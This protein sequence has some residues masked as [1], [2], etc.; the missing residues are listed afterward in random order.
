MINRIFYTLALF[1]SLLGLTQCSLLGLDDDVEEV[2]ITEAFLTDFP[3]VDIDYVSIEITDPEIVDGVEVQ[4]GVINLVVPYMTSYISSNEESSYRKVELALA[5][6]D[7]DLTKYSIA[8]EV[9]GKRVFSLI[10][11]KIYTITSR[12]DSTKLIHYEIHI[13]Q[14]EVPDNFEDLELFEYKLESVWNDGIKTDSFEVRSLVRNTLAVA[15]VPVGTDLTE[16]RPSLKYAGAKVGYRINDGDIMPYP[17]SGEALD[18]KYPSKVDLVI[19]N[20]DES[21]SRTYHLLADYPNPILFV[22]DEI[23]LPN[24]VTQEEELFELGWIHRGNIPVYLVRDYAWTIEA[25]PEGYIT[26][27]LIGAFDIIVHGGSYRSGFFDVLPGEIGTLSI[28][29]YGK[30]RLGYYEAQYYYNL[31]TGYSSGSGYVVS[32]SEGLNL[33]DEMTLKVST[34]VVAEE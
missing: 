20:A 4:N 21:L 16:L 3:L 22:D 30:S 7:F 17:E 19:M 8:P 10:A 26:N 23:E 2:D 31:S 34:T 11:P 5:S 25:A 33:Y 6:V 27:E 15:I 28:S 1:I 29:A 12:E 18:F 9:E 32:G 14:D 24:M 13:E